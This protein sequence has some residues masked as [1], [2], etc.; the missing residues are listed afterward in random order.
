MVAVENRDQ[1]RQIPDTDLRVVLL[2]KGHQERVEL[3]NPLS[4]VDD[5]VTVTP[6]TDR[7]DAVVA[8]TR[9]VAVAIDDLSQLLEPVCPLEDIFLFVNAA[10]AAYTLLVEGDEE[11]VVL[12][13]QAPCTVAHHCSKTCFSNQ[14]CR[15]SLSDF[16]WILPE[17]SKLKLL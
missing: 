15:S 8:A 12:G 11:R 14:T 5:E 17:V 2:I 13:V 4:D 9:P 1:V 6:A 3:K 10:A 16:F 7:D